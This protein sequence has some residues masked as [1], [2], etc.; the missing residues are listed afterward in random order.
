MVVVAG[1][2]VVVV[3]EGVVLVLEE[4]VDVVDVVPVTVAGTV[5]S[6]T[7]AAAAAPR[8]STDATIARDACRRRRAPLRRRCALTPAF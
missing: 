8:S 6:A 3:D 4:V 5:T 7:S 1:G 2:R